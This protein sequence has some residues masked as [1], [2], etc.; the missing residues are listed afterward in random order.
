MP[1][2]IQAQ[3]VYRKLKSSYT[4]TNTPYRSIPA[5][6]TTFND[7]ITTGNQYEYRFE[8]DTGRDGYTILGYVNAGHRVAFPSS[9]GTILLVIDST[10]KTYLDTVLRTFRNDL[11]GDGWKVK[12]G[13]F[14]PSTTVS[15]IKTFISNS[16]TADNTINSVFLIG[17]LAVPYSGNFRSTTIYPPDG[18]TTVSSPPSHEGAWPADCYYGEL[19]G[20]WTDASVNNTLGARAANNNTVGDGKFDQTGLPNLVDL[21]VGRLDLSDMTS[22][23]LTERELL[24]Q[25]FNK[26]HIF[27]HKIENIRERCLLEDNIGLLNYPYP[28]FDEHF[29]GT[30]FRN[31]APLISDTSVFQLDYLTNLNNNSYLWSYG[32]GYG[33]YTSASG[34]A[35]T[36][37]FAN[38]SQSIKSVFTGLF[39]SYFGDW[40][41]TNNLLKAP[42]AAKGNVLNSFWCGR[43]TWFFHHMAMGETIGYST[44]RT[45]NNY[46][47]SLVDYLYP[48]TD[49]NY[50]LIHP[51][52]MGDPSVRMQPVYTPT[53][54]KA[55]QDSCHSRFR[56]TWNNS[57]DTAVH[58][59]YIFRA[60]HI[61]STFSLLGTTQNNY[62]IDNSPLTGNNV[63]MLRGLKLQ[64][65]GSGTYFNMSQGI[66]DTI[67]TSEFYTPIANAGRDTFT[68]YGQ[69]VRIGV[70]NN[71]SNNTIY[72]WNPISFNRDTTTVQPTV[73]SS[74]ILFAVD[75]VSKCTVKDTMYLTVNPLPVSENIS[76]N[77]NNSCRDTID[78]SST[79]NNG[80]GFNYSW[81]F[82][83]GSPSN[84][85]GHILNNP[86]LIAY[87]TQGNYI[88]SLTVTDTT[89][90]C[91]HLDTSHVNIICSSLPLY[92]YVFNCK[93]NE[94][95]EV[96]FNFIPNE[97]KFRFAFIS[98]QAL[99][100]KN[101]WIE[102]IVQTNSSENKYQIRYNNV[103]GYEY[104]RIVIPFLNSRYTI[105]ENCKIESSL[106]QIKIIPN[107][108]HGEFLLS[109]NRLDFNKKIL[110]NI[111]NSI[112]EKIEFTQE[113]NKIKLL[114]P[115]TGIYLIEIKISDSIYHNKLIID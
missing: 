55:K 64:V 49:Y 109:I 63:Y 94:R 51:A 114:K 86:S 81:N 39:G 73:S 111:Y 32:I 67:S 3:R 93:S 72:S 2:A 59:Y 19:N 36:A 21:Q 112:G 24:K 28:Y 23:T 13:W 68:C 99:N 50:L 71:N 46:D 42:L 85:S 52:L 108:N 76:K 37:N 95:S 8:K 57:I 80:N 92:N 18:H 79:L 56:L 5:S 25:Y 89:T 34:I 4:F 62:Y 12:I 41:N 78:W 77:F 82:I 43:Q 20:T 14:S 38:S 61:D 29:S 40:D 70:K 47:A 113:D 6:D 88:T 31:T 103:Q 45:I 110:I 97:I 60:K 22:F 65:S 53:V 83:G 17:N 35:T 105:I 33:S 90:D 84:L 75:T 27:R 9:R 10:N 48:T 15:Q 26:N 102:I 1:S 16:Y 101:E 107:P 58:D 87:A 54:L 69:S 44:L 66:F 100:E 98:I 104:F 96:E 91:F 30:A 106:N 7:T 11:I 115:V 74:R